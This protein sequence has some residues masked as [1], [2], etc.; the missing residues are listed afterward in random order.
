[1]YCST[2]RSSHRSLILRNVKSFTSCQLNVMELRCDVN[3]VCLFLCFS[4]IFMCIKEM[5]KNLSEICAARN[6]VSF[7]AMYLFACVF[8]LTWCC[9]NGCVGGMRVFTS[10]KF[11]YPNSQFYSLCVVHSELPT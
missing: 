11:H 2:F 6:L 5:C 1:M 10:T 4:G 7:S 9:L 8:A 3:F